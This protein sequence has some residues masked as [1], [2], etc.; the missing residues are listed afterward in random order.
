MKTLSAIDIGFNAVKGLASNGRQAHFPSEVGTERVGTFSLPEAKKGKLTITAREGN[1]W[2]VGKTALGQSD[3]SA[4]R[5]DPEWIFTE[6]YKVLFYAALSELH[7][8]TA[9]TSL[10]TGLPLEHYTALAEKARP[11]FLGEHTF[12]RNGGR[13]QTVTVEDVFIVTQPYGSLFDLAVS[14]AGKFLDNP[15]ATG[16][17]GIADI[18]GMT[19]NLLVTDALDEKARWTQGDG[20]G[21]LKAMDAIARDI[22]ADCPGFIPKARE[23]AEWLA[24]GQFPYQGRTVDIA[25][26][27]NHHLEPL[28]QVVLAR[29]AE[30][31]SEPG[32][33]AAVLLTGGGAAILGPM[34]KVRMNGVYANVTIAGDPVFANV[35]GY[36]KLAR[37]LWGGS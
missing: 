19:L 32:R 24:E 31:W 2:N 3:Y 5:R 29:M 1:T 33:Y 13:W 9:T 21:L 16:T 20:L 30:I 28:V 35:R 11:V 37:K 4:G 34:L 7:K 8:G 12:K 14:D 27:A 36:L 23:V 6:A 25:P 26:Y 17:V 18:G 22:R 15:F 10:V